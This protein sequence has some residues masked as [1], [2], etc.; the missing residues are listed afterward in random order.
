MPE[1]IGT[2]NDNEGSCVDFTEVRDDINTKPIRVNISDLSPSTSSVD[3]I[4]VLKVWEEQH[5]PMRA[6]ISDL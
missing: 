2:T 4:Q 3:L 5:L 1:H 6:N